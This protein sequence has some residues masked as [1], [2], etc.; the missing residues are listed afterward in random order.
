VRLAAE[1]NMAGQSTKK[2]VYVALAGNLLIA[3]TKFVAAG[4]TGSSSMISEG[5]HS[6]VDTSNEMLLLYGYRRSARRPDEGHPL[7]YGR[8]LYLWSFVVALLLF[9]IGSGVSLYEGITH[10]LNPNPIENVGINYAVLAAS[11]LFE[12]GSWLVALREIRKTK[13][14]KSYWEAVRKSKNPPSFMV[15]LEDTAAMTGI[16][17][18]ATGIG[19]AEVTGKPEVDGVASICIA[20]VLAGTAAILARESKELLIGERASEEI[21]ASIVAIAQ[22][23]SGVEA[24]NGAMTIHLAPDQIAVML[25]LEFND[26]LRTTELESVVVNLEKRI[27][28]KHPE[29]IAVF[30]KPQTRGSFEK[31]RD[32][33]YR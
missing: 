27:R 2:V 3:M 10:V 4:L 30:I 22:S 8:E 16:V 14:K 6:L 26:D 33:R 24:A 31:I 17:I 32:A 20:I 19:I 15:L 18:A 12:G 25:S 29:V 28:H 5:V 1:G 11:F 23:E 13:G 9:A 21:Q 7:G